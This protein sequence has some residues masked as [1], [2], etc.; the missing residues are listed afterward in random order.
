[1][2]KKRDTSIVGQMGELYTQFRLATFGHNSIKDSSAE[3]YDLLVNVAGEILKVQVKARK[4]KN[5][6]NRWGTPNYDFNLRNSSQP[7]KHMM[8]DILALVALDVEK[9]IFMQPISSKL[10]LVQTKEFTAEREKE[11]WETCLK[12]ALEAKRSQRAL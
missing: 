10:K 5:A 3:G 1:M 12:T 4:T 7:S 6:D 11:T 2:I 9:V 8:Y